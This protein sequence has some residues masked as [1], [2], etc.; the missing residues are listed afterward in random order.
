MRYRF[1]LSVML[2]VCILLGILPIARAESAAPLSEEQTNA[3]AMLNYITVLTQDVNASKNSRLYMEEAYSSLIN[4][5]YPSAVDSRT[6]SQ[7]TSLL[8]VMEGYRMIAVKRDRLQYIYEQNQAQAI[9]RHCSRSAGTAQHGS[10]LS[11]KQNRCLARLYG[12]RFHYQ[13][14]N[15]YG[16]N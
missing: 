2:A 11:C 8:D 9:R 10:I 7:L 3:I 15:L 4:N 1:F 12:A 16:G 14:Y 6:L 5:T 13:L